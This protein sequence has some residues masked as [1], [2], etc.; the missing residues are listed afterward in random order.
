MTPAYSATLKTFLHIPLFR[1]ELTIHHMEKSDPQQAGLCCRNSNSSDT[2]YSPAT[3][4]SFIV[5]RLCH[6][7]TKHSFRATATF[8]YG[9]LR[10]VT[11]KS[12]KTVLIQIKAEF[13]FK[14]HPLESST[15]KS[16]LTQ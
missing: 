12:S 7:N 10:T 11:V 6:S 9:T 3:F 8:V 16:V 5:G 4:V 2:E 14:T 1:L 15:S 13:E